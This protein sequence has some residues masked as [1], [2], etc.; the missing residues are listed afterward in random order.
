MKIISINTIISKFKLF[1]NKE[2]KNVIKKIKRF[3]EI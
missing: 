1:I 3:K 2:N